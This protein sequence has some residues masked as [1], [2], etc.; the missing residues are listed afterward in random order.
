[1]K[2]I[3]KENSSLLEYLI[4]NTDYTKT[5]IK[6]LFKYKNITIDNKN[7]SEDLSLYGG[8]INLSFTE[9]SGIRFYAAQNGGNKKSKRFN[10][11]QKIPY[12]G[13]TFNGE[14]YS[15][16][17]YKTGTLDSKIGFYRF[18]EKKKFYTLPNQLNVGIIYGGMNYEN[19]F[20]ASPKIIYG[21]FDFNF[22][23]YP[24]LSVGA[25][26]FVYASEE[27]T[28]NSRTYYAKELNLRTALIQG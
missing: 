10:Y 27:I 6:S 12:E 9:K 18:S 3:V 17:V 4:N 5:K 8:G 26:I 14:F 15:T 20:P 1:M 16:N 21:S 23:K 28:S 7:I 2:L 25:D 19:R 22:K 13:Y 11:T 24:F